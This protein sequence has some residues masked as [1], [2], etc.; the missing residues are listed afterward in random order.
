MFV[1]SERFNQYDL[2]TPIIPLKAV[3]VSVTAQIATCDE[4]SSIGRMFLA[5][6][7]AEAIL[8]AVSSSS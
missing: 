2:T 3:V 4:S 5:S 8:K 7:H 1:A 6:T